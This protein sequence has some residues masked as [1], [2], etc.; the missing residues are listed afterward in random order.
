MCRWI[1][2]GAGRHD[3]VHRLPGR[4]ALRGGRKCGAAVRCG[5]LSIHRRRRV[6]SRLRRV[7]R[8]LGMRDWRDGSRA[9]RGGHD[10]GER[11]AERVLAVRR[12]QLSG[13]EWCDGVC[14]LSARQPVPGARDRCDE[15]QRRHVCGDER[16]ERVRGV[17]G[18]L[19]SGRSQCDCVRRMPAR[20]VLRRG[21][22]RG[23]AVRR[24]QLPVH[25]WRDVASRLRDVPGRLGVR[26]GRN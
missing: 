13:Y 19:I 7:P 22:E 20:L 25:Q 12:G 16:A 2:P 5:Q 3:S 8:R 9:M 26:D 21:R 4:F 1:I 23:A 24:G 17:R 18:R 15:L 11:R 10:H 14:E 6:A